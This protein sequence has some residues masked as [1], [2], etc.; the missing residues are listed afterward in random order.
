MVHAMQKLF[1]DM[2]KCGTDGK[3]TKEEAKNRS[4]FLSFWGRSYY[5]LSPVAP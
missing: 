1:R 3:K 2:G 4:L 5:C